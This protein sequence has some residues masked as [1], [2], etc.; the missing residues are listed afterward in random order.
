MRF[1]TVKHAEEAG[2]DLTPMIDVTM[3]LIIFFAFTAQFTKTLSSPVNLPIEKGESPS[4]NAAPRTIVIDVTRE[5]G[6]V[7]MGQK[8]A[9]E[10]VVQTVAGDVRR[11]GGAEKIDVVVRADREASAAHLNNLAAALTRAGV[12]TWK[13]ATDGEGGT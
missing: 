3:L 2:F 7:V 4:A 10:W 12:R 13:L 6:Y 9:L 11:A 8:T 1:G 5:G